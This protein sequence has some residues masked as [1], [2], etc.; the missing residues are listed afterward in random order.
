M[1]P[2]PAESYA[3]VVLNT[4]ILGGAKIPDEKQA[5]EILNLR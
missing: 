3:Q 4:Q 5:Q 2:E 1:K